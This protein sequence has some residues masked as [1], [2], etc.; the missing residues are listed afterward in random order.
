MIRHLNTNFLKIYRWNL[1][2]THLFCLDCLGKGE[3][4]R[5]NP[6]TNISFASIETETLKKKKIEQVKLREF[7]DTSRLENMKVQILS[8]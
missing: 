3:R 5:Q 4:R 2:K 6:T 8:E 1:G 7:L